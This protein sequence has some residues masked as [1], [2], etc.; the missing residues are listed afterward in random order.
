[1]TD[2]QPTTLAHQPVLLAEVLAVCAPLLEQD[3]PRL[4]VDATGGRGG[5]SAALLEGLGARDRLVVLDRDPDAIAFLQTR[6]GADRRVLVRQAPFSQLARVLAECGGGPAQFILADLGVSSPQLDRA[7]RGFSFLRDG[8]LDMR[9]DPEQGMSAAV[10][11]ARA[12]ADEIAQVLR[13]YGEE[14]EARR[15]ARA[16]VE[17]R[18]TGPLT[19]TSQLAELIAELL[20]RARSQNIHPATRTFQAIRM[21][22]NAELAELRAFLPAAMDCLLPGGRLAVISFHSLEDRLVKRFFRA[23]RQRPDPDLPLRAAEIPAAPWFP[24][25]RAI[26]AGNAEIAHN[27]RA[28]SALLRVAQKRG[29]PSHAS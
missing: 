29:G 2:A 13:D 26:R 28:R 3:G 17:R 11:L 9:M 27:P 20:P 10:W 1:V 18:S 6:F 24:L 14:R 22:V 19:R 4:W 7:E 16:I 23:D 25:G 15:I 8:P 5:H 21:H 12:T